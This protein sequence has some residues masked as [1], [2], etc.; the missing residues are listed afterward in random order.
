MSLVSA[1]P[2]WASLSAT[3]FGNSHSHHPRCNH[4]K[5]IHLSLNNSLYAD[6]G[7]R[8]GGDSQE[9]GGN[10]GGQGVP[11]E[12]RRLLHQPV[13]LREGD[14]GDDGDDGDD[15][16]HAVLG[17]GLHQGLHRPYQGEPDEHGLKHA[18]RQMNFDLLINSNKFS[19]G[20]LLFV[21]FCF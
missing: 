18:C 1:R 17:Q 13:L 6:Q 12:V 20:Q 19:Q 2:M 16:G 3:W 9:D 14:G 8:W 5:G 21:S 4:P 7:L 15:G 10:D 11:A